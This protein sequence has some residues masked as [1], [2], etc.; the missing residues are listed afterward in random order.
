MHLHPTIVVLVIPVLCLVVLVLLPYK[1]SAVLPA[2][3]WFGGAGEALKFIGGL[4]G[5]AGVTFFLVFLDDKLIHATDSQQGAADIWFR[6]FIPLLVLILS[7]F[8]VHQLLSRKWKFAQPSVVLA[9][10]GIVIGVILS[11]TITGIWFRG[12]GMQLVLPIG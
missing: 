3:K 4:G 7:L 6:G 9:L 8:A 12:P 1:K 5:G 2:G 10:A 11:L